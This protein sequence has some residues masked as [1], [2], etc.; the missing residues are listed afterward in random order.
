MIRL[1]DMTGLDQ[2]KRLKPG[3][4]R[5]LA[6][7]LDSNRHFAWEYEPIVGGKSKRPDFRLDHDSANVW[8]EVKERVG[9]ARATGVRFIDPYYWIRKA[10]DKARNKFREYKEDCCILVLYNAGDSESPLRPSDIFAAM[11]GDLGFSVP[12]NTPATA[13]L[14]ARSV[15][16]RKGG[17]MVRCYKTMEPQNS[18]ISSIAVL[19][20][21]PIRNREFEA[22]LARR[23]K[24]EEAKL[25][26]P[27]S[28]ERKAALR[29]DVGIDTGAK[30]AHVP[31]V[32]L[33]ENP[34]AERPN[35]Q[36]LF[37]G[38]FDEGFRVVDGEALTAYQGLR[39]G[40][41]L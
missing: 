10:I 23:I 2:R 7:Y 4:E 17:K 29:W 21:R 20:S 41:L 5:L 13:G 22:E 26:R 37:N 34:F 14:N 30:H 28:H 1:S 36:G 32:I 6:E 16:L 8:L 31:R 33:C 18:T 35:P 12:I 15:F 9:K 38:P 25:Q 3:A 39:I 40:E 11:L 24:L 27:L 19:Q